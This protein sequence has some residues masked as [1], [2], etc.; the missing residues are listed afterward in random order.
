MKKQSHITTT[1]SLREMKWLEIFYWL[2]VTEAEIVQQIQGMTGHLLVQRLLHTHTHL[3]LNPPTLSPTFATISDVD[4]LL[5][6]AAC[7]NRLWRIYWSDSWE[8]LWSADMKMASI[9]NI[10]E[11]SGSNPRATQKLVETKLESLACKITSHTVIFAH[12]VLR[13]R[14]ET[15]SWSRVSI[16]RPHDSVSLI[17]EC[18]NNW[19]K[20]RQHIW[21]KTERNLRPISSLKSPPTEIY[22]LPPL[23]LPNSSSTP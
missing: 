3:S 22:N 20:Y 9:S 2:E 10:L 17:F 5:L 19:R 13:L 12:S 1:W 18:S 8:V 23:D 21:C 14:G 16:F 11:V 6:F 15:P 4:L 7:V